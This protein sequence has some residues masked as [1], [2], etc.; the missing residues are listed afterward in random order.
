MTFRN[1]ARIILTMAML[2]PLAAGCGRPTAPESWPPII[3][4]LVFGD[5]FGSKVIWQAFGGSK[6]DAI[7]IDSTTSYTG[8]ASIKVT[9]PGPGDPSGTYA[10]GAF[11]TARYRDLTQYNAL[12][13]WVKASRAVTLDAA[14]L[15]NDNTGTSRYTAQR[16]SIPMTTAWTQVLVPIPNAARLTAEGGLF[17]FAEGPQGG[18]G[19]TM[20][21][22]NVQFVK[23][24]TITNPRPALTSQTINTVVGTS[25]SLSGATKTVFAVNGLDQTVTHMPGYFD[26]TSTNPAV[27]AISNGVLRV[28]G[29]GSTTLTAT[30]GSIPATGSIT[31]SA[32]PPP[33]TPA[34]NPTVPGS[35]V[36]SLFSGAYTNVPVDTWNATWSQPYATVSDASIAGNP[37]KL[38]TNLVYA[39]IECTTHPIDATAMTAFHMDVFVP[40]GVQ[41]KVKLVDFGT[42]GVYGPTGTGNDDSQSELTFTT[43]SEPIGITLG[44]W[45]PLDIPLSNFTGLTHRAHIG[46]IILSGDVASGTRTVYVDNVYFHK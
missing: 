24:A 43:T 8:A 31:V 11:T 38:Y 34:P 10:G 5:T 17:F 44:A 6:L 3:D 27:A 41:I 20:W 18:Q 35:D 30:L 2:A 21:I 32:T 23:T 26:F 14:G 29:S 15:G 16:A 19:L 42:N 39:G 33:A 12:S 7:A 25:A 36:I 45:V 9:V 37:V 28:L 22:D 4:P 1:P 46:Q 13:F 40:T